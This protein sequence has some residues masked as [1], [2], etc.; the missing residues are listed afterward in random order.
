M[1][2]TL[3]RRA[4]GPVA[5]MLHWL[6]TNSGFDVR[7]FG[8]SSFVRVEDFV[9]EGTYVLRAEHAGRG[10]GQ[11]RRPHDR[12]RH[13]HDQGRAAR[14]AEGQEPPRDPL[15]VLRPQRPAAARGP[16]RP[17]DGDATPTVCWRSG[18][19][20]GPRRRRSA[21]WRSPATPPERPA[22]PTA[23]S[24][25]PPAGP[26]VAAD[27]YPVPGRQRRQGDVQW[28]RPTTL[29]STPSRATSRRPESGLPTRSTSS[30]TGPARR[31]IARR[32]V[33][34]VRAVYVAPDGS[35]RTDN[36][37]KTAG[38]VVG[39]VAM[40]VVLRKLAR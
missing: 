1:M 27:G 8:P 40:M 29:V 33:A 28:A 4:G 16:S 38:A 36:I 18:S 2:T 11:G 10:P 14:G 15:R 22:L 7:D 34:S 35:P 12:G 5:E 21:G 30:S 26:E 20:S 23:G 24:L 25:P 17:G 32:E 13:A 31:R 3:A 9:D 6:E 37:L 19:P 39:L